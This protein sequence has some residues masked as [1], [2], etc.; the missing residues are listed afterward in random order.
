MSLPG[1]PALRPKTGPIVVIG[2]GIGGL[3]AALPLVHA[4]AEV[5]IVE[6]AATP[7][8]KMRQVNGVDAG[9]TVLTLRAVF[10]DLFEQAGEA[11][12][13]HVQL[14]PQDILARHWW[15]DSGPLD[16]FADGARSADAVGAFAG[17]RAAEEFRR[18][19][20]RAKTLFDGFHGPVMTA[21]DP[22]L[23][24]L[25]RHV[26]SQPQLIPAMAPL[27]TLTGLLRRSFTDPRLR[28]LFGRY[29]TYVGG[30][31]DRSPALLSLIWE[32]EAAGV[33]CVR[34]GMHALARA[35]A[36]LIEAKG[37]QFR[38]N[39]H[40]RRILA[41]SDGVTG[42]ELAGGEVLPAAQVV[43]NGDPRALATGLLGDGVAQVAPQTA[44][45]PRSLSATV[46][47]FRSRPRG[48]ELVHHNVFFC[49]DP[50]DEFGAIAR[51]ELPREASLYICAE[52]RG[53]GSPVP[54]D[55]RFE[56]I[57]NAPPLTARAAQPEDFQ[58]CHDRTFRTLDRF[59]LHFTPE[60]GP[61]ALTTPRGFETLFPGSAGSL[62]GQSP[63][64]M[65]AALA[66]PTAVT[67]VPGL[68]LCGGG[69]HPG[70]GVPMAAL[71]GRH[72]A[73]AILTGR[74]ST[75]RSRRTAM[76]GGTSTASAPAAPA[77]SASSPS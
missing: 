64:G 54:A 1:N 51:G 33:W 13:Q 57:R 35:L 6:R 11:L 32:A 73:A 59:G 21:P 5:T 48:P 71:S 76:P 3:S 36:G 22:S 65:T 37:G 9:P 49:A 34:G 8:G 20:A 41:D 60:P 40:V 67:R 16:L 2:A 61:G 38:Y 7:G 23:G 29:A 10:D 4:G 56:I 62:Y 14:I 69:C 31:P 46:W 27:S 15:P 55:E 44:R 12:D 74:T 24:A 18:F 47:S 72:A 26:L 39:T 43:F 58:R 19:S 75:S 77:P 45:T 68:V 66:R 70:A 25:T 30:S 52:D 28:Q 53:Q 63:H 42:V 50:R 17:A